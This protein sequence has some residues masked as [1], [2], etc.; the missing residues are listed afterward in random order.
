MLLGIRQAYFVQ[1]FRTFN[2]QSR[3]EER[4]QI[5]YPFFGER[6][7]GVDG[8]DWSI[9]G[10]SLQRVMKRKELDGWG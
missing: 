1:V 4:R 3:A 2:E 8:P 10:P 5:P 9:F 7:R 6:G